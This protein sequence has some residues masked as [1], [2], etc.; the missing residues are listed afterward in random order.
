MGG[1][2]PRRPV[3]RPPA[4]RPLGGPIRPGRHPLSRSSGDCSPPAGSPFST[5]TRRRSTSGCRWTSP[6]RRGDQ[7][8]RVRQPAGWGGG[9]RGAAGGLRQQRRGG[10]RRSRG[11]SHP[12]DGAQAADFALRREQAV[13]RVLPPRAG[14]AARL[15]GR[16]DALRQRLRAAPGPEVRGRR[17]VDLRVPAAREAAA[18]RLRRRSPD[19]RLRLREGCGPGQRPGQHGGAATGHRPRRA[20]DQH[21]HRHPAQRARPGP[22]H[23]PGHEVKPELEFAPPR[24]G[25]LFRSS[26]AI[27]KA[28]SVLGWAPEVRFEDGLVPLI[29]WFKKEAR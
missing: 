28:K 17:G 9:R 22:V 27:G 19:P 25:E 10:L 7:P 29:E 26:L 8:G 14:R 20:R 23:R 11:R 12:G 5:I 15:R 2:G 3:P 18:H 21:R 16:G 1:R 4:Q 6:P 24:P 13:G